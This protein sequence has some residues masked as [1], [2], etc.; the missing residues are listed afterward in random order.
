MCCRETEDYNKRRTGTLD[1]VAVVQHSEETTDINRIIEMAEQFADLV[2]GKMDTTQSDDKEPLGHLFEVFDEDSKQSIPFDATG[3]EKWGPAEYDDNWNG[4]FW[5][6]HVEE[7]LYRHSSGYWT[8]ISE[9]T[10][11]EA[12]C[13]CDKEA[14]R[15]D[16]KQAI[17]WFVRHGHSLPDDLE[18]R[19]GLSYFKP[20]L[21]TSTPP[22]ADPNHQTGKLKWNKDLCELTFHGTIIK[23]VRSASVAKNVVRVLDTFQ[24]D[25][26]P[27]RIDDPLDPSE[28]QQRLHETIKR[29]NDNLE[30][31]RFRADGNGQG[32]KWASIAPEPPSEPP[33]TPF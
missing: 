33:D 26:W 21:P 8:I 24:E 14:R 28:N 7:T 30:M 9:R 32:I 2:R 23:R 29:L 22:S 18:K 17:V 5:N 11:Y 10:H 27:D 13:S 19:A 15:V 12:P 3:S 4:E 16:E 31:I 1:H 20:G 6:Y 25:G